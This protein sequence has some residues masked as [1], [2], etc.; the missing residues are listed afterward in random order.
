MDVFQE[1]IAAIGQAHREFAKIMQLE[2]C[3]TCSCL[4]SDMMAAILA[5]ISDIR[6]ENDSPQ[7]AAAENDFTDWIDRA[8][9]TDLHT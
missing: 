6:K 1:K 8:A 3:R 5:V 4:H 2:K 9:G 7:L